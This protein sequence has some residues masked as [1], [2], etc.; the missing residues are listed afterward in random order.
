M[1]SYGHAA[2]L[3]DAGAGEIPPEIPP[4]TTKG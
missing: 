1:A 2:E 4:L 3:Q